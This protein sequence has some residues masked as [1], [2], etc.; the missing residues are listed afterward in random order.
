VTKPRKLKEEVVIHRS[1]CVVTE[2]TRELKILGLHQVVPDKSAGFK[3]VDLDPDQ[4]RSLLV[5]L[6]ELEEHVKILNILQSEL[7]RDIE[8]TNRN[9]NA[10]ATYQRTG[11]ALRKYSQQGRY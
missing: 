3:A 5:F 10:A 7:A 11:T 9:M 8:E 6:S 2:V 1:R 4:R